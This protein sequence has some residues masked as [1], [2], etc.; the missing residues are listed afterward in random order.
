MKNY[1][2]LFTAI[3]V[4]Y[5]LSGCKD[6]TGSNHPHVAESSL[7][8]DPESR[9]GWKL[10][11]QAY[12]FNRFTFF[13][14]LDKI[15]SC[16]LKFVE[17]YPEQEI[18]GGIPGKM[19]YHMDVT[20]R[21]KVLKKL[22]DKGITLFAYGVVSP[23]GEENWRKLFEFVKAIGAKTITSEPSEKDL[24]IVS[25]LCD[26]YEINVAIHNHPFPKH[27]WNPDS[28]LSAIKGQSARVGVCADVGHWTRSG[29]N[30]VECL[31]I[32]QGHVLQLHMKDLNYKQGPDDG[33]EDRDVHWGTG[34]VNVR[35]VIDELK[36]QHFQGML[37]VE[38]ER[39]W[40]NNV[41][42]VIASVQYFRK[43]LD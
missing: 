15:D 10:G 13:E 7:S 9:L 29:L 4:S 21:G 2:V 40:D 22:K 38:Y 19:D 35:G 31:K 42:D 36:R 5:T 27:Y 6:N 14:A 24:P 28:T 25:R 26:Q 1:L 39:N 30:A 34:I 37:S 16:G 17:A 3:A 20:V 12:T 32:L 11:A 41:P 43:A 8:T 33:A 18:G 23:D